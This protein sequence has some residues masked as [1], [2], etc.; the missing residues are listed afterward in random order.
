MS[1]SFGTHPQDFEVGAPIGEGREQKDAIDEEVGM[2]LRTTNMG[3]FLG[4]PLRSR[5]PQVTGSLYVS[6]SEDIGEEQ[7]DGICHDVDP[8]KKA[9]LEENVSSL[10]SV[11]LGT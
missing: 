10:V 11:A 7:R 2:G 6:S 4:V 5:L 3:I 8:R 1:P 9:F